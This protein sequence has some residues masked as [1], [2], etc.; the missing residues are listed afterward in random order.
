MVFFAAC[1]CDNFVQNNELKRRILQGFNNVNFDNIGCDCW[2]NPNRD[3]VGAEL[4]RIV[5]NQW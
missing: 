5:C 4:R 3:S 2:S 1:N